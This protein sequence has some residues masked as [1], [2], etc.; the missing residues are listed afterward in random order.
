MSLY[1]QPNPLSGITFL[2]NTGQRDKT[3]EQKQYLT[4]HVQV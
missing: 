1:I 3:T 4:D 2:H